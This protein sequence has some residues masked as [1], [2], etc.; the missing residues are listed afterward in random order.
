MIALG[1]S[2]GTELFLV[3]REVGGRW[4]GIWGAVKLDTGVVDRALE[5]IAPKEVSR[6]VAFRKLSVFEFSIV[7]ACEMEFSRG[8]IMFRSAGPACPC[9]RASC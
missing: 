9:L 3:L 2:R 6:V 5:A 4:I 8:R 7:D 1:N